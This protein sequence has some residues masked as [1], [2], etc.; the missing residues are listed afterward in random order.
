MPCALFR[1]SAVTTR[2]VF[3]WFHLAGPGGLHAA[4]LARSLGIPRVLI[5]PN[6]ATLSAFGMLTTDVVKDY[7]RTI[8]RSDD[9]PYTKIEALIAPMVEQ[10]VADIV[11]EGLPPAEVVVKRLLDMRYQGQSYELTIP[12]TPNFVGDFH[13]AHH[14]AYGYSDLNAP[15]EIVNLR[16]QAVGCLPRPP[17]SPSPLNPSEPDAALFDR[18]PVVLV[19][20][21]VEIP[22]FNGP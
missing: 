16:L 3:P 7:V 22:F 10:G 11:A 13:V 20:G 19:D 15:V 4:D 12:L 8:M 1:C 21:P 14:Y 6:A 5:P 18:R 17:L 9:V 2:A